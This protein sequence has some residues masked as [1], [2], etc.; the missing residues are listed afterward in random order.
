MTIAVTFSEIA[1]FAPEGYLGATNRVSA[2]AARLAQNYKTR[3][4]PPQEQQ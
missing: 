2:G 1:A 4:P 3:L